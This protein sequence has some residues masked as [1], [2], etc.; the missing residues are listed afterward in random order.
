MI[1]T[2]VENEEFILSTKD[3]ELAKRRFENHPRIS[4]DIAVDHE[5][6]DH[7]I[8][9]GEKLDWH[10]MESCAQKMRRHLHETHVQRNLDKSGSGAPDAAERGFFAEVVSC[11]SPKL[12]KIFILFNSICCSES[13][14]LGTTCHHAA[15][16]KGI[17]IYDGI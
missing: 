16:Q 15:T 17:Y 5:K 11:P 1:D 8:T 6:I 4:L 3:G 9:S 7:Y 12:N 10:G 14:P 13:F 2:R